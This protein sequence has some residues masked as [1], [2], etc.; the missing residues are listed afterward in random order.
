MLRGNLVVGTWGD[1]QVHA[2]LM[3]S[4][5]DVSPPRLEHARV[6][7]VSSGCCLLYGLAP[8]PRGEPLRRQTWLCALDE[9]AG[10][11]ALRKIR[12]PLPTHVPLDDWSDDPASKL[13]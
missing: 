7:R 3:G 4:G 11:A 13:I 6:I 2:K 1:P 5:D 9:T 10:D 12:K 8:R